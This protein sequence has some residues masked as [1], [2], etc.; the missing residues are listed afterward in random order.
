MVKRAFTLIEILLVVALLTLLASIA[1]VTHRNSSQKGRETVLRHN[2]QQIRMTLDQFH[3]DKGYY[4][5]DLQTLVDEGYL[6]EI[7][8]DPIT[9]SSETWQLIYDDPV[10]QD[11]SYEIGVFDVRSGSEDKALDGTFYYEW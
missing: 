5:A 6:R 10:D 2:L 1:A 7:P 11:S 9:K 3:I 4:P 8:L